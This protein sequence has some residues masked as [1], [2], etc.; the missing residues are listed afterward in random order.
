M[1]VSTPS[2]VLL[3]LSQPF[4]EWIWVATENYSFWNLVA[5]CLWYRPGPSLMAKILLSLSLLP[6]MC[7]MLWREVH[8]ES[9]TAPCL[10]FFLLLAGRINRVKERKGHVAAGFKLPAVMSTG[11]LDIGSQIS[12][13]TAVGWV[14]LPSDR[15]AF[16]LCPGLQGVSMA[17]C[18]LP[19]YEGSLERVNCSVQYWR[20]AHR[21]NN[22]TTV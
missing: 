14:K 2:T 7:F 8:R 9:L 6:R 3:L 18:T 5:I 15:A 17:C 20:S 4:S 22:L 1:C 11:L 12:A 16:S 13:R 10:A 19:L 21:T